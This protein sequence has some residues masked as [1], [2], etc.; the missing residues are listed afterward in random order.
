MIFRILLHIKYKETLKNRV[1]KGVGANNIKDKFVL[2]RYKSDVEFV[3]YHY[4]SDSVPWH[5]CP[6]WS[7]IRTG[8]MGLWKLP[9]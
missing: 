5:L 8:K 1:Q 3:G 2:L 7:Y 9:F 4:L 6:S